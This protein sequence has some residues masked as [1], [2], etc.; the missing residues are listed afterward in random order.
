MSLTRRIALGFIISVDPAGGTSWTDL[1]NIVDGYKGPDSKADKVDI[2]IL[3][4]VFKGMTKGQIDSGEMT[5]EI[6][7]D[8]EDSQSALLESLLQQYDPVPSWKITYPH[9]GTPTR[10]FTGH[11]SGRSE[12]VSRSK[13]VTC[14]L[15]IFVNGDPGYATS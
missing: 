8:P 6:A 9:G 13:L 14:S 11:L 4:D 2:S 15:T 5:F 3:A 1:G 10:I 7:Y 12:E